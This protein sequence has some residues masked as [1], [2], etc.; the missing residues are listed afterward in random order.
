VNDLSLHG[1]F[2]TAKDFEEA[3][4][5][6]MKIRRI[7][8]GFGREV[9]CHRNLLQSLVSKN[10]TLHETLLDIPLEK[11]RAIMPWLTKR[12]PFWDDIREHGANEYL[13]CNGEIVTDTAVGEAGWC[14]LHGIDRAL[15]SVSPSDWEFAPVVVQL[16]EDERK[17]TAEVGNH[18]LPEKLRSFLE[19]A[20]LR[21]KTWEELENLTRTRFGNIVLAAPA[22]EALAGHPF[23]PS[24]AERIIFILNTLD[25]LKTCFD[26]DGSR[27]PEGHEIYRKFFTGKKGEGGKGSVF[28]DS[29]KSEKRA[30][31]SD[32][33]FPHPEKPGETLFCPWHG[34]VQTPQLRVHF[35]TPI[36]K[37]DPL[38]VVYI[39]PKITKK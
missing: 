1:Q 30:S 28:K 18:W 24:A 37:N 13:E 2:P 20:P 34:S 11:K 8:D 3:I 22:F 5:R 35:F 4:G 9:F 14:C 7:A 32:L 38:Y 12:G 39:G 25:R 17:E 29:S 36:T 27:T 26:E 23:S 6:V 15:V 21:I 16:T 19:S 33:T 31:E 10:R